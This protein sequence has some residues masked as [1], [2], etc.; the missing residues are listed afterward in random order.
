MRR[1]LFLSFSSAAVALALVGC[2]GGGG[3][4]TPAPAASGS[5]SGSAGGSTSGAA[6]QP[7]APQASGTT[8]IGTPAASGSGYPFGSRKTAYA[9]GIKPSQSNATMDA[10]LTAQYDA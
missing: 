6:D 8:T 1:R 10:M 2:G 9:A 7:V 5:T 4:G 3:G